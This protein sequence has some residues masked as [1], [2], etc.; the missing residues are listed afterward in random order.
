MV[1]SEQT[2]DRFFDATSEVAQGESKKQ[3]AI[4]K[5]DFGE[6]GGKQLRGI[7]EGTLKGQ[8]RD[9]EKGSGRQCADRTVLGGSSMA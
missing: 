6:K 9:Y 8:R 1:G 7:P 3:L 5:Q 2:F 4:Q